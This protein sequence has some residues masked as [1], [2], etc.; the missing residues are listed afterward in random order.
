MASPKVNQ[1]MTTPY[2]SALPMVWRILVAELLG[3]IIQFTLKQNQNYSSQLTKLGS[4][5]QEWLISK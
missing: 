3:A 2:E 4:E 1:L 5:S